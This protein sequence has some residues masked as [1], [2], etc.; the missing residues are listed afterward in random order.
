[1][2]YQDYKDHKAVNPN[3]NCYSVKVEKNDP[4]DGIDVFNVWAKDEQE[5][6]SKMDNYLGIE[7]TK[8]NI[9]KI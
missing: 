3:E 4:L 2:N 8:D 9:K 1:M 5:V 7:I 6:I